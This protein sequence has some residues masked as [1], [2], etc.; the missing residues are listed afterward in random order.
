MPDLLAMTGH[1]EGQP[2]YD[3]FVMPATP[4]TDVGRPEEVDA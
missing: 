2:G 1:G 3:S 4:A